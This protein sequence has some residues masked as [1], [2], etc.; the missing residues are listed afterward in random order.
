VVVEGTTVN[1]SMGA[2]AMILARP[3]LVV[4]GIDLFCW[5]LFTL[6]ALAVAFRR[7]DHRSP[8]QIRLPFRKGLQPLIESCQAEWDR[9]APRMATDRARRGHVIRQDLLDRRA[10]TSRCS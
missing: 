2:A 7:S 10:R 8:R 1:A 4:V 9:E 3:R 5:L 6:T